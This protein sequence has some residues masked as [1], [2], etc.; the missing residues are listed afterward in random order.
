[1][2]EGLGRRSDP[3][4][5]GRLDGLGEVGA[6]GEEAV[7]GMDRLGAGLAGSPDVLLGVEVARDLDR[8]VGRARVQRAAVVGRDDGDGR[9]PELA[10]GAEDAQRDLAAVRDEELADRGARP[11]YFFLPGKPRSGRR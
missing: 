1:L 4:D 2:S 7:P 9:D 10:T 3:G 6:L 11:G 8:L 5:A